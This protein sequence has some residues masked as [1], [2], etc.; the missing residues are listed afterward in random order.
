M[1]LMGEWSVC[2]RSSSLMAVVLSTVPSVVL[3]HDDEARNSSRLL[4]AK[5]GLYHGR[6]WRHHRTGQFL[7][8]SLRH[9]G[10]WWALVLA[11]L[12]AFFA[13]VWLAPAVCG[14]VVGARQPLQPD[15]GGRVA[16]TRGRPVSP[17]G[18]GGRTGAY[19][20]AIDLVGLCA[21]GGH[22][23]GLPVQGCPG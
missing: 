13:G 6:R 21:C 18:V 20:R 9:G 1:R 11:G 14:A 3:T 4:D 8:L 7:A 5:S 23:L 17:L 22:D 16:G 19:C 10:A 15:C 2:R 12:C